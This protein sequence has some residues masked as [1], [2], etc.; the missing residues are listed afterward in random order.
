MQASAHLQQASLQVEGFGKVAD[1]VPGQVEKLLVS[2][3]RGFHVLAGSFQQLRPLFTGR[4]DIVRRR[5]R[6]LHG[7]N[8]FGHLWQPVEF[9]KCGR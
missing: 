5:S 3:G 4:R 1:Q 8:G 7:L 6:S 9:F 2:A